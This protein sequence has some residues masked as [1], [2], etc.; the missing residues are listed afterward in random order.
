MTVLDPSQ[1]KLLGALTLTA[2]EH[3]GEEMLVIAASIEWINIIH[4]QNS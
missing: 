4:Y 2:I 3:F 1:S